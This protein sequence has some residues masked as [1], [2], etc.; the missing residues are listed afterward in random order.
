MHYMLPQKCKE[1]TGIISCRKDKI[2]VTFLL[3]EMSQAPY[4]V[5][6]NHIL[7]AKSS[8]LTIL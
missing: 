3:E 1:A 7:W 2:L 5:S 4:Q 8:S 6:I